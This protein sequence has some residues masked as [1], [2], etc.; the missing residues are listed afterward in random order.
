M[1]VDMPGRSVSLTT[2]PQ[3]IVS[4]VPSLTEYLFAA[5]VGARVVGITDYCSEPADQVAHLPR[6]RGTK[7]PDREQIVALQPDLVL[8]SKEENR[9]RDVNL[10]AAAGVPVYVTDICDVAGALTQLTELARILQVEESAAPLLDDLHAALTTQRQPERAWRV[11][12]LVWRDPWM[13]I[14]SDTYA[15]DLLRLSGAH[16]VALALPGRYPRA[17]LPEFLQ[18]APDVILLP[19]EPYPFSETDKAAFAPFATVPAVR[20]NRLVFCDGKLLTWY[21]PRTREALHVFRQFGT[22]SPPGHR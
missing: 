15:D 13:A 10:L 22:D 9:Q 17:P 14:G 2:P 1:Y 19:D 8:A 16:N 20:A 5:G 7:N 18:L 11:L 3:R 4:L 12:A 21:G 6:V